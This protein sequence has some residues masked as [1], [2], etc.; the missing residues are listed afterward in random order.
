MLPGGPRPAIMWLILD[1]PRSRCPDSQNQDTIDNNLRWRYLW[2]KW[3]QFLSGLNSLVPSLRALLLL[4]QLP[5]HHSNQ[6]L[7]EQAH[8]SWINIHWHFL[9]SSKG[10]MSAFNFCLHFPY[11]MSFLFC[12]P[13]HT[14]L[15]LAWFCVQFL[16][17]SLSSKF[18]AFSA[19][20][21]SM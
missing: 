3:Q 2:Y 20:V 15:V 13:L 10:F 7:T 5:I 11:F 9:T 17:H 4:S 19:H 6:P 12:F 16:L 14:Y 8:I 21:A 18:T 1:L